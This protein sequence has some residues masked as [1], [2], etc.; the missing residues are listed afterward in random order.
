MGDVMQAYNVIAERVKKIGITKA[1]LA[2]RTHIDDE[3]LRRSLAG[4][5][6]IPADE[7]VRLCKELDLDLSDFDTE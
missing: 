6:K 1:E 2:R 5:R 7:F 3:L 4:N